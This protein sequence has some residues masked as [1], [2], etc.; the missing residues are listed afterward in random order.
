MVH[1]NGRVATPIHAPIGIAQ[2]GVSPPVTRNRSSMGI[3][4]VGREVG[5]RLGQRGDF[6]PDHGIGASGSVHVTISEVHAE[7]QSPGID[8]EKAALFLLGHGEPKRSTQNR[9]A[10]VRAVVVK[11]T[12][13]YRSTIIAGSHG[14]RI[15]TSG[16]NHLPPA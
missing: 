16:R 11:A 2:L 14:E 15:A 13:E 9:R 8:D 5:E 1:T 3:D 4:I 10:R 7:S 6:E 12:N